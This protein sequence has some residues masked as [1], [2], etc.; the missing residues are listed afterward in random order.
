MRLVVQ[1]A[2]SGS[3]SVEGETVGSIG[4]GLVVL[5]GFGRDDTQYDIDFCVRKLVNMRIFPSEDEKKPWA[6]SVQAVG[7]SLLVV[8]QFTLYCKLNGNKPDFHASLAGAWSE[9]LYETFVNR[10]RAFV[11]VQ[12]GKF[13]A[14]MEVSLVNDGPVTIELDSRVTCPAENEFSRIGGPKAEAASA[15]AMKER[16]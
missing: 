7:G 8:S 5:V 16:T 2:L 1:R 14:K 15:K 3:V 4:Q 6:R 10:L 9:P 11:P 13:G 12:T